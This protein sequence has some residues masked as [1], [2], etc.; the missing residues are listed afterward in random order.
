M[1]GNPNLL[2]KSRLPSSSLW[3]LEKSPFFLERNGPELQLPVR[4]LSRLC[5]IDPNPEY[6]IGQNI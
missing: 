6:L 2:K 4:G 5:S 3:P 1:R